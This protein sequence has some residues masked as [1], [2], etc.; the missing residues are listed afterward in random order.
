MNLGNFKC[1][2]L[3]KRDIRQMYARFH[4]LNG[5]PPYKGLYNQKRAIMQ[6]LLELSKKHGRGLKKADFRIS[7]KVIRRK[8]FVADE[9]YPTKAPDLVKDG[10]GL[11][12][13]LEWGL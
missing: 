5:L 12:T 10:P 7:N 4:A 3:I 11:F 9:V 6:R 2:L 8:V 13:F 1:R